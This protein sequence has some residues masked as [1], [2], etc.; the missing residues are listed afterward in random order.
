M[1]I[2]LYLPALLVIWFKRKGLASTLGYLITLLATQA[3]FAIPFLREDPVA[4]A[5]SAFDLGR[6]FMFKWTVNWRFLGEDTFLSPQ[7]AMS[8]L[9]GHITVLVGF[10]LFK[11][12]KPDGGV[13]RVLERGFRRPTLPAG[14]ALVTPDCKPFFIM[15]FYQANLSTDIATV[16]FTSNLIGIIFARSLH[17]QFYSWYAQQL[18]FLLWRT[19]FPTPLK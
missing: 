16:L 8:L 12:C 2:L 7:L 19:R 6:V 9:V 11:W 17:Y 13:Y 10:G 3:L 5:R 1:S 4:Y 15:A 18:P 14:L